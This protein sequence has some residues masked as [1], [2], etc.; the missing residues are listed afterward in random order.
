MFRE[1]FL[2][3]NM[4]RNLFKFT[5]LTTVSITINSGAAR[6]TALWLAEPLTYDSFI[7]YNLPVYPGAQEVNDGN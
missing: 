1:K 4:K 7:Y 6:D 3:V 5:A 2:E